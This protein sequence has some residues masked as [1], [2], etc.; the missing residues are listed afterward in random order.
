MC[1]HFLLQEIFL[2]QGSNPHLL[3]LLHWQADSLPLVSPMSSNKPKHWNLEQR[4][5]CCRATQRE[6]VA[7][8]KQKK[9]KKGKFW[10]LFFWEKFL[11]E[12]MWGKGCNVYDFL[13]IGWWWGNRW[14]SRNLVFSLELPSS[15]W[16]KTLILGKRTERYCHIFSLRR[17]QDPASKLQYCFLATPPLFLPSLPSLI[18]NCLNLPFGTQKRSVRLNEVYFLQIGNEE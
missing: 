8:A 4:K 10:C 7:Y 2:T 16:V 14:C 15:T 1:C 6:R 5:V 17:N 18:S 12:N 11:I 13:L 9:K 3:H